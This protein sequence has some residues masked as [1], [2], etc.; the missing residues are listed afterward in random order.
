MNLYEEQQKVQK[1]MNTTLS[2]LQE[3]PWLTQRVLANVKGEEPVKRKVSLALVLCIVLGFAVAGTAYA[4]LASSKVAEFFGEHWN[5]E[6][7]TRLQEGKIAQIGESVTIGDVVITLDEIV[8]RDRGLYG[9][10]S[11]RAIHEE[12][13]LVPMDVAES[14]AMAKW[15]GFTLDE[16]A[17]ALIAIAQTTGGKMITVRSMPLKIGVDEGTMLMPGSIGYYDVANEDGS[18]IYSFEASDGFAVNEGTTYQIQMEGT[19]EQINDDGAAVDGTRQQSTWTV[20]C[21]PVF[22]NDSK[23]LSDETKSNVTVVTEDGYDVITPAEY[24][25]SGTMPVYQ[26][27]VTDFTEGVDPEW[28]N[29]TGIANGAGTDRVEFN[30]HAILSASP[31]ALFYDEYLDHQYSEAYS[32]AIVRV[33]WIRDWESHRGEFNLE[34]TVLSGI[35]LEEAQ[36]Q[37]EALITKLGLGCNRYSCCYALD[38]SLNRIREMGAVYEKAITDG[39]LMTDDDWVPYDYSSIPAGEEGFYL[40]YRPALID[41]ADAQGRYG[42]CFFVNSRGIVYAHLCNQFNMGDALES[43]DKLITHEDAV[44]RLNE[45]L[46]RSQYGEDEHVVAV[47]KAVLTYEP[48]RADNREEGMIFVP[49]WTIIYRDQKA[50]LLG[51]DCYAL[52]NAIDGLLIDASFR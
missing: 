20:S 21:T 4:L 47:Q 14:I 45:E 38:M 35:T 36:K 10:G 33:V 7:G 46:N 26:A 11:I 24:Q 22:V 1:A 51:Y 39:E 50:S 32:G 8:Y 44:V 18:L 3:D 19:V 5:R 30:D 25:E 2:G 12:D 17:K 49:A 37:V 52:F 13:V 42:L 31:E 41:T 43:P 6:L 23:E 34:Q 15:E 48:V 29:T 28:F 40:E 27:T 16:E 9:V